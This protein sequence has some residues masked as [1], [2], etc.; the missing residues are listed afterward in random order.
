MVGKVL[1]YAEEL[2]YS[3]DGEYGFRM[4]ELGCIRAIMNRDYTGGTQPELSDEEVEDMVINTLREFIDDI[5]ACVHQGWSHHRSKRWKRYLLQGTPGIADLRRAATDSE[6]THHKHDL[7][8]EEGHWM[9]LWLRHVGAHDRVPVPVI[10]CALAD[11]WRLYAGYHHDGASLMQVFGEDDRRSITLKLLV[12]SALWEGILLEGGADAAR[13]AV[14]H[15][16]RTDLGDCGRQYHQ[17]A[18]MAVRFGEERV[19]LVRMHEPGVVHVAA[20][21][22]DKWPSVLAST[23][24]LDLCRS[25][26]SFRSRSASPIASD[27]E[28][29]DD[30]DDEEEPADASNKNKRRRVD[31]VRRRRRL[32]TIVS[33]GPPL[34]DT[35]TRSFRQ[36]VL[37]GI[38]ESLVQG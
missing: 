24:A 18:H 34:T 32:E 1:D 30:E 37:D 23:G 28:S 16:Y 10:A 36:E 3:S 7:S 5:C 6:Q 13:D 31:V 19:V 12:A 35:T 25:D 11:L 17:L 9:P 14:A 4:N 15:V 22:A 2:M 21:P 8:H 38:F 26:V 20:V 27:T 33:H 29:D